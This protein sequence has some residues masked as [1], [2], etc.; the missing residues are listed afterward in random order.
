MT[1]RMWAELPTPLRVRLAEIAAAAVGALPP[2]DVP[3]ALRPLA[4]F[5]PRKR[6]RVGVGQLLGELAASAAFRSAVL[7]WWS[8]HRGE[9]APP[10]ADPVAAAA[11]ALLA[12]RPDAAE[13]IAEITQRVDNVT[14]RGE[15][16][17]AL[18]R[19]DKLTAELERMRAELT[20]ARAAA[21]EA[22]SAGEREI[23][24]LRGR[25]R[26][27]G[28]RLRLAEDAAE[29]A[30]RELD[31][32]RRTAELRLSATEAARDREKARVNAEQTRA[33]RATEAADS[34][35]E[36]AQRARRADEARLE[37]LIETLGSA[38]TGLRRELAL[39][40]G[41]PRPA[42][43]VGGTSAREPQGSSIVDPAGL[44]RLLGLPNVH[45]IVDG[46]N[47]SKAGYPALTLFDQRGRLI[48]QL[49]V[50]AARTG[51]EVTVVF[52]G[53]AVLAGPDRRPRGVRVLFSDAGV[54]ADDV[55]RELVVAEPL[56]RSVVVVSS[57]GAVADAARRDGA[58]PVPSSVLLALFGHG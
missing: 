26:A 9:L 53:A 39:D 12:Q 23:E 40:R 21:R 52:D 11:E 18:A 27:L 14:L 56:G 51:V 16:D 45:V 48:G 15:R 58:H 4:R 54:A 13:R 30:R 57:D 50:L 46:Y 3:A 2:A 44:D 19:A 34:A 25:L 37:V 32:L 38:V 20:E 41:G 33:A 29:A 8:A 5:A 28:M 36:S 42:D 6:A 1:E 10:E 31:E 55:I 43:L 17:A 47:V 22:N 24:R 35:R 49:G 7:T